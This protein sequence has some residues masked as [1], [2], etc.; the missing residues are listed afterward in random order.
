MWGIRFAC[1][2]SKA[3]AL[4]RMYM[5]KPTRPGTHMH[6]RTHAH[7]GQYVILV[8]IKIRRRASVLSY[9]YIACLGL[10]FYVVLCRSQWPSSQRWWS[11]GVAGLNATG[12]WVSASC[13]CFV[14]Q[15]RGLCDE[16]ITCL[17][18]SYRLWCAISCDLETSKNE[19][20]LAGVGLLRQN[21]WISKQTAII[22]LH[23]IKLL[24]FITHAVCVYCAVRKATSFFFFGYLCKISNP[25][26][27]RREISHTP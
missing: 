26:W 4:M 20:A 2:I 13:E 6:T 14:L 7:T 21:K 18:E 5:Y 3:H 10:L 27:G 19:A 24:A 9:T 11:A 1:W 12:A 16:P 17:E 23:S 15:G 22:S 8:A 25:V